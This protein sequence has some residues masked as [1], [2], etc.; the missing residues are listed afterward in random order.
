MRA[1]A[2]VGR[3]EVAAVVSRAEL[4]FHR[5]SALP[6]STSAS[7]CC[8]WRDGMNFTQQAEVYLASSRSVMIGRGQSATALIHPRL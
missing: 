8:G 1:M 2:Q 5:M 7:R 6:A 3:G 4:E